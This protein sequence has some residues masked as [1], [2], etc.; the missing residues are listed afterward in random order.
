MLPLAK[1]VADVDSEYFRSEPSGFP[2]DL[3]TFSVDDGSK[4]AAFFL[5]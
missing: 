5:I 2:F 1:A 4:F 3:W